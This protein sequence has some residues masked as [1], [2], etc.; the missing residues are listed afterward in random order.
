MIEF[1][2]LLDSEGLAFT[3]CVC[4]TVVRRSCAPLPVLLASM[5]ALFQLGEHLVTEDRQAMIE[6][7]LG[8]H[9]LRLMPEADEE[10]VAYRSL[11]RQ[12][13]LLLEQ[14]L[15]NMKVSASYFEFRGQ[16]LQE[17]LS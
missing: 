1:M 13:R 17:V 12:P 7:Y 15:M 3:L 14:M 16:E 2:N 9:M 5:F 4:R 8:G 11:V 6:A 10:A